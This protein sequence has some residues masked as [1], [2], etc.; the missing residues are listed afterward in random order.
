MSALDIRPVQD[1]TLVEV[2]KELAKLDKHTKG[3]NS[4]M[5]INPT[6]IEKGWVILA[7]SGG[8]A[9]GFMV[10]RH[11]T[12]NPWTSLYYIGVHPDYRGK[13]YGEE[14]VWWLINDSPHRRIRLVCEVEN[15]ASNLF[16][17]AMGFELQG[18]ST[19]KGG[20]VNNVWILEDNDED[21]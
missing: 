14:L 13:G 8:Q 4:P 20:N 10:V 12:R 2:V 5:N 1:E 11:C 19:T 3:A 9:V 16:Y 21:A 18:Q 17:K 7:E 6:S 15:E